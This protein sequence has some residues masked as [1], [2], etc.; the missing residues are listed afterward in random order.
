M[1][2]LFCKNS[3]GLKFGYYFC[4]NAPP[5]F[6]LGS[7]YDSWQKCQKNKTFKRHLPSHIKFFVLYSYHVYF[8]LLQKSEQKEVKDLAFEVSLYF[9]IKQATQSKGNLS[10]LFRSSH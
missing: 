7:K 6:C 5:D 10:T 8:I 3:S 9:Y 1:M 2:D 4:K